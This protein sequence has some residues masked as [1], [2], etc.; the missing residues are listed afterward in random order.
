LNKVTEDHHIEVNEVIATAPELQ[1]KF[2][3]CLQL[4]EMTYG[5]RRTLT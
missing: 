3:E 2:M 1:K 4:M 5:E